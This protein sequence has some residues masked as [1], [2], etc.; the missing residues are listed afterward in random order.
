MLRRLRDDETGF[1]LIEL[2]VVILIIG[3]L[4]A[5]ALPTFLGQQRKGQDA[6]A[7]S[8]ARNLVSQVESCFADTQTYLACDSAAELG[9]T[10]LS[11]GTGAGQ[12]EVDVSSS[13]AFGVAGHSRSG[14]DFYI[15]RL[16]SGAGYVR[17]CNPHGVGGCKSVADGNGNYW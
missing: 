7:K 12:V 6:S 8:D 10:G 14:A 5:I 2:L 9:S 17:T 13:G 15:D 1:T 11:Y 16:S 3:I 4:A